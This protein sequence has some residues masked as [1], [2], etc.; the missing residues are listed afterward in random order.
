MLSAR[1]KMTTF[2]KKLWAGLVVMA[3]LSPL[4]ILL[5]SYFDAEDAWGEWSGEK[6]NEML[7]YIPAGFEE[8]ADIWKAPIPDYNLAGEG[9][10]L[11][12]QAGSYIFSG[13]L[14]IL[15]AFCFV[16]ALAR[17]IRRNESEFSAEKE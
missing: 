13:A 9:A 2:Q 5:P 12:I 3:L 7:G 11:W 1:C 17:I 10:S 6:L 15:L 8:F 14:G 16:Y 4:G